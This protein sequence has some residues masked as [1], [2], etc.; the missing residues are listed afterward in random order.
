MSTKPVKQL[1]AAEA[2]SLRAT[3]EASDLSPTL[4]TAKPK[5]SANAYGFPLNFRVSRELRDEMRHY[6]I[7]HNMRLADVLAR[8]WEAL[9][10]SEG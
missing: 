9:K 4:T 7:D 6:A 2:I 8:A 10:H 5:A 1:V 3:T